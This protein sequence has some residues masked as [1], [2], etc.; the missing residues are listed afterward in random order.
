MNG[1][2]GG[3]ISAPKVKLGAAIRQARDQMTQE[4]LADAI[5]VDQ[6]SVSR[7]ERDEQRPSLEHL[8]AVEDATGRRRGF[9]LIAAGL[10]D[11]TPSVEAAIALDPALDDEQRGF[12][13]HAY[14]AAVAQSTK[15]R[16]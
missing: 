12:V 11:A 6:P 2:T 16:R 13:L 14:R 10:V 4:T 5:G 9:I 1:D 15:G 7:W 8:V 3:R